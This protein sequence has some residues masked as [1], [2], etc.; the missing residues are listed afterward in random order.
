MGFQQLR[1]NPEQK[2]Y[3][4]YEDV[5][6]EKDPNDQVA[7]HTQ[8]IGRAEVRANKRPDRL[9]GTSSTAS[10]ILKGDETVSKYGTIK[11][12]QE[13]SFGLGSPIGKST[14]GT[15]NQTYSDDFPIGNSTAGTLNQTYE[16]DFFNSSRVTEANGA[17]DSP[18][19]NNSNINMSSSSPLGAVDTAAMPEDSDAEDYDNFEA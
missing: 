13:S 18:Q 8:M 5:W 10:L 4:M 14:V 3:L 11:S 17:A 2:G 9:R 12:L 7:L 15:L 6:P 16:D 1:P 19:G